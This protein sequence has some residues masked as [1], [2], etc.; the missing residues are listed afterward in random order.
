MCT[1]KKLTYEVREAGPA[2][3]TAIQNLHNALCRFEYE[4]GFDPSI[5]LERSYSTWFTD[6]LS[7]RISEPDG[8]ALVA[9]SQGAVV[10]YLLGSV[11]DSARGRHARLESMF[12]LAE[13]RRKGVGWSLAQAFLHW[14][15]GVEALAAGVAVAPR[16]HAAVTLYRKLG[17]LDQTLILETPW[18]SAERREEGHDP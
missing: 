3:V 9:T 15:R 8:S 12:V 10:G 11:S 18:G 6:Y 2:D 5:D 13:H 17:F 16:N 1:V 4:N 7:S 14:M